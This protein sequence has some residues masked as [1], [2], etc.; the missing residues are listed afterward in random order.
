MG[1]GFTEL[2]AFGLLVSVETSSVLFNDAVS[3]LVY[4]SSPIDKLIGSIAG[5][6]LTAENQSTRRQAYPSA[7]LSITNPIRAG[8][9]LNPGLLGD[10]TLSHFMALNAMKFP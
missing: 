8:L 9:K 3:R 2:A 4:I 6:I 5:T 7:T 1:V 10:N